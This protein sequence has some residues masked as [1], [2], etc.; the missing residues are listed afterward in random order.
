[1]S[2]LRGPPIPRVLEPDR[3]EAE[4]VDDFVEFRRAGASAKGWFR[5]V[6]CGFGVATVHRLPHCPSCRGWLWE[7]AETSPFAPRPP[8]AA[9]EAEAP[10]ATGAVFLAVALVAG[11]W[12]GLAGLAFGLFKLIHG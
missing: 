4:Q 12:L 3:V 11:L 10:A 2:A 1:M 8:A 7:W 6:E 5:C 9:F